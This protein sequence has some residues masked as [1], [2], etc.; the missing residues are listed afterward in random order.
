MGK[1]WRGYLTA[2]LLVMAGCNANPQ[3]ARDDIDAGEVALGGGRYDA[4]VSD[5][6]ESLHLD[7]S[8]QAYYLR[9]RAE[10]DRP[11]PDANITAADLAKAGA[12]YQAALDLHPDPPLAAR[13]R[14]G[15]ANI[16]FSH[17]EYP[18]ALDLW[19]AAVDD[20]GE[21]VWRAEALYR[22]G[23]CQ[24]RLARFEEADKT[25]QRIEDDYPDLDAAVKAHARQGVRAFFVQVADCSTIA[26]AQAAL[27]AAQS[28]GLSC[29][30]VAD[31]GLYA[32]RAGPYSTYAQAQA[33]K[34]SVANQFPDAIIGP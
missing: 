9:G 3:K 31:Q 21:P 10:E 24:Q 11:K 7:P 20:L 17:G 2:I 34:A 28:I 26:D 8:A 12:D 15:L 5:A 13:C 19:S 30:Q 25:F 22:I 4:A 16:A 14:A 27:H 6:D 33:A 23:E 18:Q 29:R 32:I 1:A